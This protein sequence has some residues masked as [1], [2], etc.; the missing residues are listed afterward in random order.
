[1]SEKRIEETGACQCRTVK[2][3]VSGN[4]TLNCLCHCKACSHIRAMSPVH[5]ILVTPAAGVK[6]TEGSDVVMNAKGYGKLMHA[7]CSKCSCMLYEWPEGADFKAI[8]PTNFHIEDGVSCKL[9]KK[10]LPE[11]HINYENR[12][13]DWN[14][15]LPKFK[16]F[17][18]DGKVDHQGNDIHS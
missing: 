15:S 3:K 4:V 16:C 13:Y 17:P 1:M 8:C 10:Y 6:I 14:D 2:F 11:M 18:P 12:H 7:F 9:P 5:L